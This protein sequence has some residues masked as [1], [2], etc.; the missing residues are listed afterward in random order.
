MS[1]IPMKVFAGNSNPDL[2]AKISE[3][4][5]MEPG[6]VKIARFSDGEVS[7]DID[8]SVRGHHC[9]VLQSTSPPANENLVE[10]LVLMDALKRASA[11][12]ITVIIPYYG[13]G[14][15]DRKASPRQ[16]ITAKL[17]ADL[18]E[19][20][21]ATR[22]IAMDLHAAQIQ[23]FFDVPFDHL[24]AMP[25]FIEDI[26]ARFCSSKLA[27]QDVV[28]VSP[29]AGGVERARAYAKR[30]HSGL[31]IIDKRRPKPGVAEVMNIIGEVEGK[32]AIII[33]DM[34]DTAGTLVKAAEALRE[35]S[36]I[37]VFSYATHA[38]FSGPAIERIDGSGLSEVIVSDSIPLNSK[39]QTCKKIRTLSCAPLVGEAISRVHTGASIS[40]L[41]L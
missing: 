22:I 1:D 12:K 37:E 29:D 15:Q 31:A 20:A 23:G 24:Y 14:R 40:T 33:D 19:T 4:L 5:K 13:Y 41:F 3:Y 8:E 39:A 35:K 25:I 2:A 21:G 7:L 26:R 30:L 27:T 36:V 28:V 10:L 16:P 6:K 32:K 9:F 17:V 11:A 18:L 38:V 34:I